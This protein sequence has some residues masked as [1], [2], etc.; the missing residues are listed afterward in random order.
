MIYDSCLHIFVYKV[1]TY[2]IDIHTGIPLIDPSAHVYTCT[3]FCI[4][5]HFC[6]SSTRITSLRLWQLLLQISDVI[7][8]ILQISD[9]IALIIFG[10]L[11]TL[12]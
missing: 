8:L 11:S 2:S 6:T 5:V 7:E 10:I 1:F 9:D 12:G 3:L 4:H